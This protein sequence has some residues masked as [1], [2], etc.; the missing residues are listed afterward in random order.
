[1]WGHFCDARTSTYLWTA[2]LSVQNQVTNS[3]GKRRLLS[4]K[5]SLHNKV[6]S[7]NATT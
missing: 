3:Q 7:L 6:T 2:I 1:M 4:A 5:N